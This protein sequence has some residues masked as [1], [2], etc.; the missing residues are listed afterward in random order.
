M[1]KYEKYLLTYLDIMGFKGM[2]DESADDPSKV[3]RIL[4]ILQHMRRQ[5]EMSQNFMFPHSEKQIQNFSDLIVRASPLLPSES[6]I[7]QV[8]G[9]CWIL[10]AIQCEL[11]LEQEILLRGAMCLNQL[12]MKNNLVFGPALVR[13]YQLEADVA[14]F[15]RIVI[16][17]AIMDL[18]TEKDSRPLDLFITRADDGAYFIDYLAAAFMSPTILLG[19][20]H[21]SNM[22]AAHK[23]R[24]EHKLLELSN[25][26]E[27]A[28]Q[29][30]I[31]LALY[32]NAA[33]TRL[34][35][36]NRNLKTKMKHWLI[37][38]KHLSR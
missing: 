21:P 37:P 29:K 20:D 6:V 27:R 23:I 1:A 24:V 5:A 25:K 38:E 22:L 33:V 11:I 35:Q 10:A 19:Y 9:E 12:Y 13:A 16:D 31:W 36:S 28:K 14:V 34:A 30:A 7:E 4:T 8:W 26:G 17:T 2:I 3:D 32:H 18:V 15:P